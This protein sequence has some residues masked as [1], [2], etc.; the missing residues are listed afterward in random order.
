[1]SLL[2]DAL[3]KAEL[4]KRKTEADNAS[5]TASAEAATTSPHLPPATGMAAPESRALGT[6]Q[7]TAQSPPA[8]SEK[9]SRSGAARSPLPSL[10]HLELLDH[11]F[12]V[13]PAT[14]SGRQT[15]PTTSLADTI[16]DDIFSLQEIEAPASQ[17][18]GQAPRADSI[19]EDVTDRAAIQ[20][21]FET[22][23]VPASRKTFAITVGVA[24]I[25]AVTGIGWYFWNELH[26]KSSLQAGLNINRPPPAPSIPIAPTPTAVS[27][28]IIEP[29]PVSEPV[30][31]QPTKQ[32]VQVPAKKLFQVSKAAAPQTDPALERGYA[33]LNHGDT[34][35][36]KT[37]YEQALGNDP[38]NID[39]LSGLAV[40]AQRSGNPDQA[41]D[42]YRRILEADP[43]HAFALA[44][45]VSL[46]AQMNPAEAETRLKQAL[47]TQPDSAPLNFSLGNLYAA[48]KRWPEAQHV[49]FKAMTADPGNPDYLFNLAVSLDQLGQPRLAASY[50]AQA[51]AATGNRSGSFDKASANERLQKLQQQP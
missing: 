44:G 33:A 5:S 6:Q 4:A 24:S 17:S 35:A 14:G 30:E 46:Q 3:K 11:E 1:M 38:R 15:E 9:P 29:S 31:A 47:S 2:M 27:P 49:Y 16:G 21:L 36:A 20:N 13:T 45:L 18:F 48:A 39:A 50:Y 32:A 7:H 8:P 43:H 12:S 19:T 42:Y 41:A 34:V 10:D 22:K 37:A 26:P 51:V 40:L 23:Q 28:A 25:L